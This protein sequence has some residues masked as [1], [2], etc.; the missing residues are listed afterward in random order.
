MT[1][2][3]KADTNWEMALSKLNKCIA[4]GSSLLDLTNFT[5]TDIIF[6]CGDT[7]MTTQQ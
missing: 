7:K 5:K 4:I 3:V 2:V 1:L 6:F